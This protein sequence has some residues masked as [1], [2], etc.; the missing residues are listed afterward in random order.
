MS[1]DSRA[2]VVEDANE[3]DKTVKKLFQSF[4]VWF[5]EKKWFQKNQQD[6]GTFDEYITELNN[7][8][9]TW[10]FG[11]IHGSLLKYKMMSGIRSEKL[12]DVLLWKVA[13]MSLTK[14]INICCTDDV[15]RI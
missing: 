2:K 13:E 1:E 9:S 15:P 4:S 3:D 7:F 14:V 10:E 12:Q 8:V 5:L 11:Q 6:T